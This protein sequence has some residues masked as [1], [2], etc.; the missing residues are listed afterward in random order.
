VVK[1][2]KSN[3]RGLSA[4]S[5]F[6]SKH[7][8]SFGTYYDPA[9]INCASLRVINED[10]V[11]PAAGF[12]PHSH[13]DMEIITYVLEGALEHKDSLGSGFTIVPGEVQCMCAGTGITHSELN[14]S[15]DKRVH[16]LQIWIRPPAVDLPPSYQQ[17]DFRM[18]RK[19]GHLT[20][21]ASNKGEESS[22][23]LHQDVKFYVLDL[24]KG[25]VFSYDVRP[26]RIIWVQ[27]ARGTIVLNRHLL[28][29]GDGAAITY[30]KALTFIGREKSEIL[31]FDLVNADI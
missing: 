27:V 13:Q 2:R 12:T 16:F 4:T 23:T 14:S 17:K 24:D 30:E 3:D 1:I 5:G 7:T 29:Q 25:Q 8:F 28:E 10:I 18:V 22:L 19:S 20:L 11:E 15:N 21:L 26:E 31:I 9:H 6:E